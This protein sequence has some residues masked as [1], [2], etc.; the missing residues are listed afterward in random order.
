[1]DEGFGGGPKKK[2]GGETAL[3]EGDGIE[4]NGEMAGGF[5]GAAA[6]EEGE[7]RRIGR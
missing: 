1:M 5:A 2:S 3:E 4:K 7:K 6:G